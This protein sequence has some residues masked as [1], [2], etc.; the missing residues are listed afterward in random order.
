MDLQDGG[1]TCQD[2]VWNYHVLIYYLIYKHFLIR[3]SSSN[4]H[5]VKYAT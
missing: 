4:H 5:N 3:N 1:C 2:D